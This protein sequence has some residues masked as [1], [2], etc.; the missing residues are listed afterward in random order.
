MID[1]FSLLDN[2]IKHNLKR[3]STLESSS[4]GGHDF[5]SAAIQKIDLTVIKVN[6]IYTYDVNCEISFVYLLQMVYG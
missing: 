3:L 6:N 5:A 1:N 2:A 4:F